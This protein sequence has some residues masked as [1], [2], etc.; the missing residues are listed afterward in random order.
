METQAFAS[1]TK[2]ILV[3]D[4]DQVVLKALSLLLTANGYAVQTAECGADAISILGR[5]KPDLVLMDLDFPPD[6]ASAL[7]DGFLTVNWARRYGLAYNVP[8]IILSALDPSEYQKR[9]EAIGIS[10]C[11]RKPADAHKLLQAIETALGK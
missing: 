10:F 4:D 7:S 8:F 9:A 2:K 6:P 3:V 1:R 5:D 11:F